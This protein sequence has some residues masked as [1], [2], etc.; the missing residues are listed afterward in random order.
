VVAKNDVISDAG[1]L[2]F[3]FMGEYSKLD[4]VKM[5]GTRGKINAI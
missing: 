2:H 4:S 5:M 3:Y 1:A